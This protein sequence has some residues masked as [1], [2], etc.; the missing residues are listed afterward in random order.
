MIGVSCFGWSQS[1]RHLKHG[2]AGSAEII[3]DPCTFLIL[4][5]DTVT[6][7]QD[8]I[9]Q[10]R[11]RLKP[12]KSNQRKIKHYSICPTSH[13]LHT[14]D[15]WEH[16][17]YG[18]DPSSC[19]WISGDMIV[20]AEHEEFD[21]IDHGCDDDD[22]QFLTT[23]SKFALRAMFSVSF[24]ISYNAVFWVPFV[25]SLSLREQASVN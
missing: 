16:I 4:F 18:N 23:Q 24:H 21:N 3:D 7:V 17:I 22:I 13:N 9:I 14:K 11:Y 19:Q 10:L 5:L 1:E 12:R 25:R 15:E 6:P 2:V 8:Y 20:N